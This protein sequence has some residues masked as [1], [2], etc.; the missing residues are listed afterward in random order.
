VNFGKTGFT[1]VS[2]GGRGARTTFGKRGVTRTIGLPGTGLSYS[3][4][5]P[6]PVDRDIASTAAASSIDSTYRTKVTTF[7][8]WAT[9]SVL[10]LLI[11]VASSSI[12]WLIAGGLVSVL[13]FAVRPGP[14]PE[15]PPQPTEPPLYVAPPDV[16]PSDLPR[17]MSAHLFDGSRKHNQ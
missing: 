17:T 13:T 11:G 9:V 2:V 8:F 15:Q 16:D 1:S 6:Y 14:P 4:T 7:R 5:T 12:G 10:L 3:E